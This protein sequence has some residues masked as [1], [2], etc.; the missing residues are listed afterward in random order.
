VTGAI[1]VSDLS[2]GAAVVVVLAILLYRL[3]RREPLDR[4]AR[5][6][7]FIERRRFGNGDEEADDDRPGEDDTQVWPRQPRDP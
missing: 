7:V 1:S 6:G 2:I 4:V 3:L 5:L